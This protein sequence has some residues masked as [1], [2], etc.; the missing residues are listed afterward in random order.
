MSVSTPI[1]MTLSEICALALPAPSAAASAKPRMLRLKIFIASPSSI[2]GQ[3][4][5]GRANTKC[6]QPLLNA[7]VI[8][9]LRHV[10]VELRVGDHVHHAAVFHDV[11]P[12]RDGG[13]EME[14]L[15]DQKNREP[16]CLELCDGAADL[17]DDD[18]GE[19]LCGFVE[20]QKARAGAQY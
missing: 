10:G 19:P 8:V 20:Q 11:M 9:K 12:V 7:E 18:G 1:L 15:F 14:V 13:R 16:L 2:V 3:K 4:R 17:L 5:D 6:P